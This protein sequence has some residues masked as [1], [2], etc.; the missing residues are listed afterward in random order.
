LSY[1]KFKKRVEK[2]VDLTKFVEKVEQIVV[3]VK[4]V[5][6]KAKISNSVVFN[7]LAMINDDSNYEVYHIEQEVLRNFDASGDFDE[8]DLEYVIKQLYELHKIFE[9]IVEDFEDKKQY[10][11]S[12]IF[13]EDT[14][15]ADLSIYKNERDAIDYSVFDYYG[16]FGGK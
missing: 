3:Y 6:A 9:E 15:K 10:I 2:T 13:D 1:S 14:R 7:W 4:M 8:V 5:D 16:K 11:I 12:L